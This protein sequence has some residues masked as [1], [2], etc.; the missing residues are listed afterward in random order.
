MISYILNKCPPRHC[1]VPADVPP[2]PLFTAGRIPAPP[3]SGALR[4]LS[5]IPKRLKS[6]TII[7]GR[8]SLARSRNRAI[9]C[10]ALLSSKTGSASSCR[11]SST[12]P[13]GTPL[14]CYTPGPHSQ[15]L[16]APR[17]APAPQTCPLIAPG[18]LGISGPPCACQP[19]SPCP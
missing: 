17:T 16:S 4:E 2:A 15:R 11:S 10:I 6:I 8:L 18:T 12:I 19:R 14:K 7:V 9:L 3:N 13:W 1:R 5:P